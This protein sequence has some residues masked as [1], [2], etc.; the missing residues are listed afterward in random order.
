MSF[1]NPSIHL[2]ITSEVPSRA[3][4]HILT[5]LA[6]FLS[7]VLCSW[8]SG[9]SR[10][11]CSTVSW[12]APQLQSGLSARPKRCR[13]ELRLQC[14][15]LSCITFAA[16]VQDSLLY[17]TG[18]YWLLFY[19]RM[20]FRH[21]SGAFTLRFVHCSWAISFIF[22]IRECFSVCAVRVHIS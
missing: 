2:R 12:P 1:I 21:D 22:L 13:Y 20:C 7:S 17:S 10:R 5:L 8:Y 11:K 4:T 16:V 9:H 3:S 15:V 14:P 6:L 18:P 19:W